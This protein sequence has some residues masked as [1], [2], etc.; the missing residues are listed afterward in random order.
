MRR[1]H[2]GHAMLRTRPAAG[3]DGVVQSEVVEDHDGAWILADLTGA[4]CQGLILYSSV[5]HG[6]LSEISPTELDAFRLLHNRTILFG[7]SRMT[8]HIL[9]SGG[10]CSELEFLTWDRVNSR[11]FAHCRVK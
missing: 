9:S 7:V 10:S 5:Y 11:Y 3:S 1:L 4:P 6:L 2:V 8:V